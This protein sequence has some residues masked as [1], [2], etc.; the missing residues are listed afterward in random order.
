VIA[1][2]KS[3]ALKRLHEGGSGKGLP[4]AFL[5]KIRR[6]IFAL[7]QAERPEDLSQPGFG[8]HQ[9]TGDRSGVWSIVITRNWRTTFRFDGGN[10]IEVD[11]EDYH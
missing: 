9:L 6:A 11:F 8:L 2:F 4:S 5:P 7:E 3:K 1:S 10:A